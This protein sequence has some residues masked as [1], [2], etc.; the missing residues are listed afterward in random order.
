MTGAAFITAGGI[1]THIIFNMGVELPHCSAFP[2]N[3]SEQGRAVIRR[4]YRDYLPVAQAAGR[5]CLFATDTWRA[6]CDWAD[7]LGYERAL[8]RQNNRMSVVLCAEPA[9]HWHIAAVC[10]RYLQSLP[11]GA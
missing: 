2:L 1:E 10:D 8:L 7:R 11:A 6:S 9:D 3:D 4:Y 5:G